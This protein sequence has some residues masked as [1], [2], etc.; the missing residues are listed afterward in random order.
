MRI[1]TRLYFNEGWASEHLA[2]REVEPYTHVLPLEEATVRPGELLDH[3]LAM[4]RFDCCRFSVG[5]HVEVGGEVWTEHY[6]DHF[7]H[8]SNWYGA[9]HRLLSGGE[10]TAAVTFVW[11]RIPPR[12]RT[13]GRPFAALRRRRCARSVYLASGHR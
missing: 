10:R 2:T 4:E 6:A 12:A 9:L 5:L 8:L 11:D 1:V 3:Y 13:P 7:W